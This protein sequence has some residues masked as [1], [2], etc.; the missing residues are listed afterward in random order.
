MQAALLP[1]AAAS[2]AAKHLAGALPAC[3]AAR[4]TGQSGAGCRARSPVQPV[5]GLQQVCLCRRPC[6]QAVSGGMRANQ[7]K[8][9]TSKLQG[10]AWGGRKGRGCR[11]R[12]GCERGVLYELGVHHWH[13]GMGAGYSWGS[14]VEGWGR[15]RA[16]AIWHSC[17]RCYGRCWDVGQQ[18]WLP[19]GAGAAGVQSQAAA[20]VPWKRAGRQGGPQAAP[21]RR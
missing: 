19:R 18:P 21:G 7:D 11:W 3:S 2:W 13:K 4:G 17:C 12:I 5:R 16:G 10:E 15:R 14:A 6:H 20:G 8:Q 9:P 1:T